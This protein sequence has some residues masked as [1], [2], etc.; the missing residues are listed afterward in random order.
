MKILITGA[1]GQLGKCIKDAA[2]NYPEFDF[3]FASRELL[4]IESEKSVSNIFENNR[5]DYCINTAA[6]TNV[7]KAESDQET[8]FLTNAEGVKHLASH[9]KRNNTTL[10]QISTDYVFDGK[11]GSPYS[12]EDST[13]SLNIY[14][15]SKLK[16]EQYVQEICQAYYI[17]RTSWLYSQYGQNFYDTVLRFAK[18]G[19]LLTVTTEQTGTPTNANDLAEAILTIIKINSKNYG[20]YNF[21][22]QGEAT[23]Y[24]FAKEI[25]IQTNQLTKSNL[26][27]TDYYLTF[28]ARPSYSVLDTRKYKNTFNKAVF[29]WKKS[30]ATLLN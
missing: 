17:L 7:E 5:F 28:A 4:N 10:I 15:A 1:K 27:K 29:D 24:D 9:C 19:K 8:A 30:L 26:A 6:Y 2:A 11:K 12:E 23:W 3:L 22:N 18:E 16:G 20:I 14:G 13:N 25:L 21:S